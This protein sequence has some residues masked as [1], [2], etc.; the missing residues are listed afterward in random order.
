MISVVIPLYNKETSIKRTITS[1][2]NQTYK[3]FELIIVNDGSSDNGP[4]IVSE[5]ATHDSRIR[6]INQE[7]Q[8]VSVARNRGVKE[9]R[10]PYI[11]FLDGDD[12]WISLYLQSIINVIKKYPEAGMICSAGLVTCDD[13]I[14]FREVKK[15]RNKDCVIN[16]FENPH[17]FTHTSA[18]VVKKEVFNKTEGFPIGMRMNQD[19]ACFFSIAMITTVIYNGRPLSI[20]CGNIPGQTTASIGNS[21]KKVHYEVERLNHCYKKWCETGR[22]NKTYMVFTKYE[23][24]AMIISAI[25]NKNKYKI[26]YLLSH[27]DHQLLNKFNSFEIL[28]YKNYPFLAKIYILWT[29]CIWRLHRYP[30][31]KM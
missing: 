29:K 9:S 1:V 5:I 22:K 2:L 11:A 15:Y 21:N 17:V 25:R 24:R 27:L 31:L 14:Y 7:N 19:Y 6:L 13:N 8:G 4:K 28:L 10:Y 16:Y 23:I 30:I 18:T 26:D 20:Y 3:N 12:E